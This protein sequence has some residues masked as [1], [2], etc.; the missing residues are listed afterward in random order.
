VIRGQTTLSGQP[1]TD[2]DLDV[3]LV[4]AAELIMRQPRDTPI[5]LACHVNPDGD[6]L[7]SM[8][9][10]GLGLRQLGFRAVV[11]SFPEPYGVTEP[12]AFLPG[13]DLLRPP[14][15]C[16]APPV[17][18]PGLAISFDA[19]SRARLGDL[20]SVSQAAPDWIVLDHHATNLGFGTVRLIDP[21]APATA[22]LAAQLLDRLGVRLDEAIATCLYVGVSTDTGSFRYDATTPQTHL[23]AARLLAAGVR[24]AEVARRLFD[25]RSFG[26]LQLLADVIGRAE[27]DTSAAGGAGL[28]AAVVT[29]ADLDR[30][31]QPAHVL[32][33]FIDVL[34]STAEAD[35]ACLVKP[36]DDGTTGVQWSVSLRSRG[37]TDVAAV[38]MAFG[39]GG[40][41][42]ASGYTGHG[43]TADVLADLRAAL[44]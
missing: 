14:A 5:L 41:R 2:P 22:V 40:H 29:P 32:E 11:A 3:A 38:A 10:F 18:P 9:G 37:R 8:L 44:G 43:G 13:L 6:A 17:A 1:G 25:T 39:G 27:L 42:L 24:P 34:R 36:G 30:Y 23:L 7:G 33:S 15:T 35:V 12:F 20:A 19:A 31:G 21:S 16:L 28:V 26:A 4:A